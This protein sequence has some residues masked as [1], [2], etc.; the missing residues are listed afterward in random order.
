MLLIIVYESLFIKQIYFSI[1]KIH[2]KHYCKHLFF[3]SYQFGCALVGVHPGIL[4]CQMSLVVRNRLFAYAK[5][6]TQISA[7]VFASWIVQFLFHLNLKF[8][9]TSHLLWLYS[10]V[11]VGPGRKPG[12]PVFSQQGSYDRGVNDSVRLRSSISISCVTVLRNKMSFL[13]NVNGNQ[14][15]GVWSKLSV[16]VVSLAQ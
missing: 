5:T 9:A 1:F 4:C 2:C 15:C 8:Q 11:C 13:V 6:K 10:P 7:F 3:N 16:V 14:I 12:R